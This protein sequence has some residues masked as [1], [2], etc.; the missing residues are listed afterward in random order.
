MPAT[1]TR[2]ASVPRLVSIRQRCA[3]SSQAA[4]VTAVLVRTYGSTPKSSA[5]RLRYAPISGW[6][7]NVCD[8]SGFGANENE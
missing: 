8:Q 6:S 2:A 1:S 4:P 7:A 3:C 5:T